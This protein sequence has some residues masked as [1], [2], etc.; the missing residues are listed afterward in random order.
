MTASSY[1]ASTRGYFDSTRKYIAAHKVR[2][3]II[4]VVVA[5]AL[6]WLWGVTHPTV[7]QTRYVLA[8][9][10]TGTI[11][12]TV[13]ESGQVS[14]S[15]QV[16]INPQATGQI[17]QVLVKDGEQVGKGQ[18]LAYLNATDEYNAVT[19]AK[20]S[21]QSAQLSLQK[22]QEPATALQLTQDQ[23]S[24]AKAQASLETDQSN[25]S[26]D[27]TTAYND[28]VA[29]FL[30]LP[31]IQ[32]QLQDIETGTEASRGTQWNIDYYENA[33]ENWDDLDAIAGRT[34]TYSAYTT[35]LAAYN[36]AYA[37][38]QLTSPSSSTSTDVAILNETYTTLQD[39]ENALNAANSFIQFYENQVKN[40]NQVPN[41]EATTAITTL[42]SDITKINSHLSTLLSDK[43]QITSTQQS[44]VNDTSSITEGQQT[45]AQLQGGA[46]ALDIQSDQLNIQ[47]QQNALQQA[48][49]NLSNYTVSAPFAG[50]VAN[51]NLNVGD[52]VSSGTNAATLITSADIVDISVNEVDAAKIALGEQATLTFDAIP[53]LSLTGTVV[54]VSPL[55]TV[56]QGVVSYA[57]KI[58]FTTQD[59]RVKAG[60]TVNANIQTA[61]HSNVLTVP[62]S[63]ITTS[64]G[65]TY[66]SVFNP[67]L[68]G[69]GVS[70]TAGV[71]SV[72]PPTEIPV[73]VGITDNTNT[74]ITSGLTAGEQIVART[75]SSAAGKTTAA[76]ATSRS[77]FGGGGGGG[78]TVIRGIGG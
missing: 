73:T 16:T 6:Y 45:L 55:G 51:L 70:S 49:D 40:N 30:D 64:G 54:D 18:P 20:A 62:A 38:F 43:N 17:T 24:V 59:T 15:N 57:I 39:E 60:M 68:T 23:D 28:T 42:S 47:Q 35:T 56:T 50:T 26:N 74:E 5:V 72:T 77:G 11:V 22:L 10:G 69:A 52:T 67:P 9:V 19:S 34:S 8:T 53:N 58:G 27:Y 78:A 75:S 21:L 4:L 1:I 63:A 61:V 7:V 41:A 29:S 2:S 44:I 31:S 71:V 25:L 46:D 12:S 48:E 76:S 14:P 33:T 13:S 37:D 3:A 32:T 66:V 36:K 65:A